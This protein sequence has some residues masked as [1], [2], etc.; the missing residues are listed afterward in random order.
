MADVAERVAAQERAAEG[1]LDRL[2]PAASEWFVRVAQ[3][4]PFPTG[5]VL[6]HEGVD[7]PF[8]G[9]LEQGRVALRLRLPELGN[10]LTIVTVEPGELVGWSALVKPYRATVDAVA[11]Q[12]TVVRAVDARLLRETLAAD[13]AL[14]AELPMV[15]L[16][17]VSRRLTAS[18]TQLLD[19]FGTRVRGPW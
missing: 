3:A 4:I 12:P 7:T 16:E 11:T 2:S 5:A 13:P 10:R 18:W 6:I 17:G 8:L 1:L 9:V 14:A 19:L 15:V